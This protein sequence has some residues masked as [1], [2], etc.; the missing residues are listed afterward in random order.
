M[1]SA[2][3]HKM[4]KNIKDDYT[5]ENIFFIILN[6]LCLKFTYTLVI[7]IHKLWYSVIATAWF[8]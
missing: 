8:I 2:K 1:K 7:V 4:K 3:L 5:M 6:I